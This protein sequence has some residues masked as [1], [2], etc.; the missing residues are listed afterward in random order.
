MT[1]IVADVN[2]INHSLY[3]I[4]VPEATIVGLFGLTFIKNRFLRTRFESSAK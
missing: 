4:F 2:I 1:I 3:V